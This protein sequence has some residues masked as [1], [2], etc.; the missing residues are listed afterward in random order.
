MAREETIRLVTWADANAP[1]YGTYFGRRNL[2]YSDRADFRPV[3][4][5]ESALGVAPPT[6]P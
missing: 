2:S 6:T 5:L 1:F 4:T 3:P